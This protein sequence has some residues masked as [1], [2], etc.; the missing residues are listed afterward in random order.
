MQICLKLQNISPH[1]M[2]YAQGTLSRQ[3]LPAGYITKI[4]GSSDVYL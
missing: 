2:L 4:Q 1:C 3:I